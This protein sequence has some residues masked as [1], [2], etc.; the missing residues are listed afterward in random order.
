MT[1]LL[2][3]NHLFT[4]TNLDSASLTMLTTVLHRFQEPATYRGVVLKLGKVEATFELK[5][6]AACSASQ[7]HIDLA[8]LASPPAGAECSCKGGATRSFTLSPHGYAVFY[9]SQGPGGYAVHVGRA[10]KGPQPKDFD[11][12]D[13]KPG[14]IFTAI[15]IRPGAYSVLNVKTKAKAEMVV[16]Y[17]RPAKER[18]EPPAPLN[19]EVTPDGFG[20][21][22]IEGKPA[23]AQVYRL[24]TAA[25]I[26]IELTKPD[27]G[28]A[29][30]SGTAKKSRP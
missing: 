15:L 5:V 3:Q 10:D 6:D 29:A 21:K 23:Q 19:I 7:A 27:D 16:T 25:Q 17:V 1:T 26:Q 24:K 28:P 2:P 30:T 22:R 8:G 9:V 14:D 12:R 13:L 18:Y 11:S 20:M 4:Q